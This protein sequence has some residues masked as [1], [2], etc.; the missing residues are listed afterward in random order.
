MIKTFNK[1]RFSKI[2]MNDIYVF[3]IDNTIANTWPFISNDRSLY[4]TYSNLNSFPRMINFL[5]QI[6]LDTS[7]YV[8]FLSARNPIYY[9]VTKKWL[10][11]QGIDRIN[12]ILV[13]RVES[14]IDI[15]KELPKDCSIHFFDDLSYNQENRDVRFYDNVINELNNLDNVKYYGYDYLKYFQ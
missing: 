8:L 13:P 14:K 6:K 12:L 1:S 11:S 9:S 10:S 5:K 4:R 15:L 2:A 7:I 3:D